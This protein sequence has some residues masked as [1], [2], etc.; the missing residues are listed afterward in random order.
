MLAGQRYLRFFARK[1]SQFLK[2][3]LTNNCSCLFCTHSMAP[4]S[5]YGEQLSLLR[6]RP[7]ISWNSLVFPPSFNLAMMFHWKSYISLRSSIG[8]CICFK[9]HKVGEKVQLFGNSTTNPC[10]EK[11][12]ME[13]ARILSSS[14]Q[15]LLLLL[16]LAWYI[17]YGI[18]VK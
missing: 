17:Y 9:N 5:L 15:T 18:V 14:S 1:N 11:F 16:L 8:Y 10:W 6:Q 2:K 7:P 4:S 13:T 3:R 12:W